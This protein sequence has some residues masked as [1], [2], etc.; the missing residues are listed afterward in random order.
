MLEIIVYAGTLDRQTPLLSVDIPRQAV[1]AALGKVAMAERAQQTLL[2]RDAER[3]T[4]SV[5]QYDPVA[6][7]LAFVA[8]GT[9]AA[10]SSRRFTLADMDANRQDQGGH[11]A[12]PVQLTQKL[13]RL[14]F[15]TVDEEWATYNFQGGRRP[16]F[17]PLLG[18]AGAS[19]VRGQGTGEHPHHTGMGLA[20]GGHSEEGSANIWSDWDEP[21]YGPGGRMVHRGFRHLHS[22]PV[23]GEVAEDLTYVDAYGEPIAE[24]VRTIR[25]WW[26]SPDARFLDFQFDIQSCR[27]RG[28][29]PFLFMIRLAASMALP[30]VGRVSNAAGYPVP[31]EKG[32]ERTYRAAWVDGS[33]PMGD[34][35]PP[36]PT[37]APETLVDLPGA[38]APVERPSDGPWNGIAL[39]DHPANHGFPATVGK[40][41]VVQQITQAHYPPPDAPDGPF[42]FRQR[43]YVH[44]G[45]GEAARVAQQAVDYA[46]PCRV[47]VRV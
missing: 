19:V 9:L 14:V 22:G 5:A 29:R 41:A 17:W 46:E 28:P 31:P 10:G 34:P 7:R 8:P 32:R 13:D 44:A 36:P 43:V 23:Y 20:Y 40:Y 21:P 38:K 35:P 24:E 27:D 42:T 37:A 3:T 4:M 16:Y 26:G 39:F 33:G 2:M 18:P 6:G 47:E 15:Q 45:D 12:Y 1:A 25:A 11:P 30:K